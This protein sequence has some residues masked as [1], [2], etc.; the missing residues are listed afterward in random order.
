MLST[1][2]RSLRCALLAAAAQ[3][4]SPPPAGTQS[5][6]PA[7]GKYEA[8]WDAIKKHPLPQWF[9]DAKVGLFPVW[10]IYS[11]PGWAPPTGELGKIDFSKWFRNNPYA[12][13]YWN[14]MRLKDSA[15]WQYH[16]K[17]YGEQFSYEN[18]IPEFQKASRK[19]DPDAWARLFQEAGGRYVVLTTKFHDGYPLWPSKVQNPH[20]DVGVLARDRD[21]VGELTEAVRKRGMKMGLY[22]SGGLDWTFVDTPI[23]S[24]A[25]MMKTVP[26]SDEYARYA[27]AHCRELIA[28]YHPE[29]LW[30]DISYPKGGDLTGIFAAYY[31]TVPD[32]VVNNRFTQEFSDFTTPEYA[33]YNKITAK[34]WEATRGL[35]FSFGYNRVEGPE[36]TLTADKLVDL[37]VDIVSKNGNL[38]IGIGPRDDGSIPELQ[39]Q[40]L[41]ELGGW[42]KIAG[43]AIYGTQPWV[44]A[45]RTTG[46]GGRVRFTKKEGAAYAI[47]LDR[48]RATNVTIHDLIVPDEASVR[49]LGAVGDLKWTQLGRDVTMTLPANLPGDFAWALRIS[50]APSM[51]LKQ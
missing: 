1:F 41:R 33:T 8:N 22:Y 30:D 11:T 6:S 34:K 10:G 7:P 5:Q 29:V 44:T 4:L 47:L 20:R 21:Y 13:W 32:G 14:G 48:P 37:L 45:E 51:A 17:T 3:L 24:V 2:R 35:G 19:W 16:V 18:F 40:R 42:L 43:E 46:E 26:Q 38:L 39:A 27:D 50:P 36:H 23:D 12:E 49:L 25:T 15:T 28:R 31:N 9:S